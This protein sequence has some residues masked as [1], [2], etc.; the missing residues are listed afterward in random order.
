M[1]APLGVD[2]SLHNLE[3]DDCLTLAGRDPGV[4]LVYPGDPNRP[5]FATVERI[6]D[7]HLE[8]GRVVVV[9]LSLNLRPAQP[10][11]S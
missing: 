1:L 7:H 2:I 3:R 9:N 5:D 8:S 6:V 4:V 11:S 10:S